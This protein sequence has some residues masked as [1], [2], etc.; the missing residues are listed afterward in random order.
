MFSLG[1]LILFLLAGF[2]STKC[3]DNGNI[4]SYQEVHAHADMGFYAFSFGAS[5]TYAFQNFVMKLKKPVWLSVTDCY[6][7]GDSFQVF[8]FGK[9]ILVTTMCPEQTPSCEMAYEDNA[10]TCL[11]DMNFCKGVVLLDTGHHNLTIASINSAS[12]GGA[13]FLRLDTICPQSPNQNVY[14]PINP[15]PACCMYNPFPNLDD[16]PAQP[17]RL[18]NQM[19]QYPR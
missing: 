17:G 19:V 12:N 8:D 2:A 4:Y 14:N 10:W 9:P 6:C 3:N 1:N 18:C 7:P 11:D 13:A 5:H 15:P 16:Y